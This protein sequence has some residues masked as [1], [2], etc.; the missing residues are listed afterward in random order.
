[1][2]EVAI[3]IVTGLAVTMAVF[4]PLQLRPAEHAVRRWAG[5]IA[6]ALELLADAATDPRRAAKAVATP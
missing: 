4:P 6:E 2:I 1:M 5:D 3:G